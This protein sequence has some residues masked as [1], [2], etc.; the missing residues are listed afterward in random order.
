[1]GTRFRTVAIA[2]LF[3]AV[4]FSNFAQG[5][6]ATPTAP[7]LP[8]G[9]G[10]LID[11]NVF[12]QTD[13]TGH[14]R[15]NEKGDVLVP[16]IGLVHVAGMT[17]DEAATDI[18][19]RYI[20]AEILNPGQEHVTV[21]ISEYANQGIL[22]SGDVKTPG[23]YPALGVRMLND[24][25]TVAGGLSPTA[26][27]NIIITHRNAPESPTKVEYNP[28]THPPAIPQIQI[29][30]GDTIMV[31]RAGI[32]Y[33][34]GNVMKPGGYVIEGQRSLTVET[35][36]SLSGG[37]GHAAS[38][39]HAHLVRTLSDGSR[40]DIELSVNRIFAGKAPDVVLRDGDLLW[41]PTSRAK[42]IT[43]QAITSALGIGTSVA[44]YRTAYQ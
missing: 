29:L 38:L 26:S 4:S 41:I 8:I 24:V 22:V 42:L 2:L 40:E 21:F 6:A 44:I 5:P 33:V 23:L 25:L 13:L 32:V 15:V 18:N 36:I 28:D 20:K 1:M 39:N 11:L 3:L 9:S 30:P 43:E 10:D 31:P 17:A 16:L 27:S 37:G 34:A 35:I 19:Q 12:G 7:A 14:F